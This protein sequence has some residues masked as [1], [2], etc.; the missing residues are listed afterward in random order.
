MG[1]QEHLGC[2]VVAGKGLK[3]YTGISAHIQLTLANAGINIRFISQG[4]QERCIVYGID[5]ADGK[6]AVKAVYD[7]YLR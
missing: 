7:E 6:E 1:F 5:A 3:G 4:A 2:I